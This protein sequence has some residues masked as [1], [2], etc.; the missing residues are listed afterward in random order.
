MATWVNTVFDSS[1]GQVQYVYVVPEVLVTV[2]SIALR[3][4][5]NTTDVIVRY[6]RTSLSP[7]SDAAVTA[8]AQQDRAAGPE[9]SAQINRYLS[10]SAPR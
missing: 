6:E 4:Q 5:R 8:M 1:K 7:E 3:P 9:W 10:K 2:I